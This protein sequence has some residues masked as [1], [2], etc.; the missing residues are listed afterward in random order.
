MIEFSIR[1][2]IFIVLLALCWIHAT[3]AATSVPA[4]VLAAAGVEDLGEGRY[5]LG[6]I[7]IN[8][9]QGRFEVPGVINRHDG[10]LEFLATTEGAQKA[11]E[12]LIELQTN[13][14]NFNLA[15][16]LIGLTEAGATRPRM[17]F[18][19]E[20]VQGDPV[21]VEVSWRDAQQLVTR[22]AAELFQLDGK[23]VKSH[24]WRYIASHF[25]PDG[26]YIAEELGTLIGFVHDED[27]II[28]HRE[29]LGL[30][31]YGGVKLNMELVP[32]VGYPVRVA[33]I[34]RRK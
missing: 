33:V 20:P 1:R 11:Y 26:R 9:A 17:H 23:P 27:S 18:D 8:Q 29:G 25:G 4:E 32:A 24:R 6:V 21:D 2:Q 15:C 34:R 13:A 7:E 19:P 5:R 31:D 22:R 12:S 14:H 28:Q 10:P 16:I 30:N 3:S